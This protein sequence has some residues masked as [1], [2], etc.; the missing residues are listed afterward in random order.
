VLLFSESHTRFVVEAPDAQTETLRQVFALA[1]AEPLIPLGLVTDS[2]R[3]QL[4]SQSAAAQIDLPI[5]LLERDW[6]APLDWD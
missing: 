2:R 1:G 5:E 4:T 6:Q 3:L